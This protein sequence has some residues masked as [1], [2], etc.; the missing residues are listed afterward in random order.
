MKLLKI[1]EQDQ[2]SEGLVESQPRIHFVEMKVN[3]F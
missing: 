2:K 1:I 3:G